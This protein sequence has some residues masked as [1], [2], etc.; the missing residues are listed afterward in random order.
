MP[1]RNHRAAENRLTLAFVAI[2]SCSAVLPFAR[3]GHA[4]PAADASAGAASVELQLEVIVNGRPSGFIAAFRQHPD[5][6]LTI[7]PQQLENCGISAAPEALDP[8]GQVDISKLPGVS[9]L[10]DENIQTVTFTAEPRSLANRQLDAGG[11]PDPDADTN[12]MKPTASPGAMLNYTLYGS[13]GGDEVSSL[14]DFQG[15]SASFDARFFGPLGVIGSS[16]I[17]SLSPNERYSTVRLDTHWTYSDT[18]HIRTY[19]AGD[20]ISGALSWSRPVRLGGLQIQRNFDVRPDI[21]T[22]PLPDLSGSAAVP[23]TVD[24]YVDG[25]RRSSYDLPEGP[26]TLNNIPAITGNA[27]ARLVVRD[28]LG[29]ETVSETSLYASADLLAEGLFDY[30]AELGF[31]RTNYGTQSFSYDERLVGLATGRYGVTDRLTVEGH[32]E[33]GAD[34]ING[35]AGATMALGTFGLGTVAAAAS[36]FGDEQGYLFA[37]SIEG[38]LWDIHWRAS[39]QRTLGDYNDI[40]SVTADRERGVPVSR[41]GP[42]KVLDQFNLSTPLRFDETTLNLSFTNVVSADEE[43][44]RIVG[45]T[46][47]RSLGDRGNLFVTAFAD[48]DHSD[49]MGIFAGLTWSFDKDLTVSTGVNHDEDGLAISADMTK[50]YERA[51][52]DLE[53]RLSDVE[54]ARTARAAGV[55]YER[56]TGRVEGY[57][58]QR[59]GS[60]QARGQVYGAV[61]IGGGDVFLT[62]RIDDAFAIVDAGGPD[63]EVRY[64]NR[65]VG[66]TNARGRLLVPD[67]RSYEANNISIDPSNLPINSTINSTREQVVPH[68]ESGVVVRFDVDADVSA[69]LVTLKGEDG[70]FIETGALITAGGTDES[71]VVGYDGQAY[72][73]GLSGK[74]TLSVQQPTAGACVAEIEISPS[75]GAVATTPETICRRME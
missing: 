35:G 43:R 42:P 65:P 67:L 5:G 34:F 17:V 48:L 60:V 44:S 47:N 57:V 32:V 54:G 14:L 72:V 16:Q 24:L 18:E 64:E 13:T 22:M 58:E 36:R 3:S 8:D 71:F 31:A 56:A 52:G 41:N 21:I 33:G 37:A 15:L 7:D 70:S 50:R 63:V 40:A 30:S 45:V 26:F 53:I 23:S 19:R 62:E 2:L 75:E 61:V 46:A 12:K 28:A 29:R 51:D 55:S 20:M 74:V 39:T 73:T 66:R 25:A 10:Y 9:F 27:T 4:M 69:A 6:R 1:G 49:S 59:D 11:G 38:E 68:R